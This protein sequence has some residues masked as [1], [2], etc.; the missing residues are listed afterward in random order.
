MHRLKNVPVISSEKEDALLERLFRTYADAVAGVLSHYV[1]EKEDIRDLCQEVFLKVAMHPESFREQ[2]PDGCRK[3]LAV[4]ARN[5]A[6]DFLRKKHRTI[7]TIPL[8]TEDDLGE[9][10]ELVIP[11]PTP[12]PEE[13]LIGKEEAK[14]LGACIDRLPEKLRQVILLK[15]YGENENRE[16]A[17]LLG[18]TETAVRVRLVRA[19]KAL[20]RL[21]E[22]GKQG[23]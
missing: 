7:E 1:H 8:I 20:K 9:E 18:I 6:I 22:E 4:Y 5:T 11:D 21:I 16:I 19:H 23:K 13:Q 12:M 3:L 15:Y 10:T 14:R 17:R 2:E